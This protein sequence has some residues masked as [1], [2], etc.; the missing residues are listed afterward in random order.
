M[1]HAMALPVDGL[2]D[3]A[4]AAAFVQA[5]HQLN[6]DLGIADNL[7]SLGIQATDLDGLVDGASKVTRLLDNNPRS[8]TRDD[9]RQIYAAL[10]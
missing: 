6:A 2:D 3:H 5:L 8:M 7:K 4:A 1:A 9:M 10:I